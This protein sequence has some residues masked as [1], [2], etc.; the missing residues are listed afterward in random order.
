MPVRAVVPA[1]VFPSCHPYASFKKRIWEKIGKNLVCPRKHGIFSSLLLCLTVKF[2][3][4]F[5]IDLA[6]FL[7]E[8]IFRFI[9]ITS[10]LI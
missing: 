8:I 2:L 1:L 10:L 6:C 9:I 4:M 3:K 5:L 7:V